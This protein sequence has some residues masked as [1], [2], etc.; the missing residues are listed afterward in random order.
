MLRLSG[1]RGGQGLRPPHP[2]PR[3]WAN[4]ETGRALSWTGEK[5]LF[6]VLLGMEVG[7][8]EEGTA[9]PMKREDTK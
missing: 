6:T 2:A 7:R 8:G 4:V 5:W 3:G 1:L 9:D